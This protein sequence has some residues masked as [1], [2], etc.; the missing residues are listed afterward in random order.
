M[1]KSAIIA[2][3]VAKA[4]LLPT[5]PGRSMPGLPEQSRSP[6]FLL[7]L[8]YIELVRNIGVETF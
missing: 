7:D 5:R 1:R 6:G 3:S 4:A 2:K 8:I